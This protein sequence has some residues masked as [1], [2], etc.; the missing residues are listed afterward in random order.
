MLFSEVCAAVTSNNWRKI[1]EFKKRTFWR[2]TGGISTSTTFS[3]FEKSGRDMKHEYETKTCS[4]FFLQN[5]K[6]KK[7]H[8]QSNIQHRES[9]D[10][11]EANVHNTWSDV[12]QRQIRGTKKNARLKL[13][14]A[15]NDISSSPGK[16]MT[17]LLDRWISWRIPII[18]S[19]GAFDKGNGESSMMLTSSLT[20]RRVSMTAL[21]SMM[22]NSVAA[23][24]DEH[25][26][27]TD[28]VWEL[29]VT[30]ARGEAA[31]AGA[32]VGGVAAMVSISVGG[33]AATAGKGIGL[34]CST[35]W[36]MVST[37]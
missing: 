26:V 34:A 15:D 37:A 5:T 24:R 14:T 29:D 30:I 20:G 22:R 4:L 17:R 21:F 13:C 8:V 1:E 31:T 16:S 23:A 18:S 9:Y 33:G 12:A 36:Q 10:E 35:V 28:K 32:S 6:Q 27:V 11:N 19:R 7:F 3:F 2:M 25:W